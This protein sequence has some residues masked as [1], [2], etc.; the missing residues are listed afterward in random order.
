[1]PVSLFGKP[2]VTSVLNEWGG[3]SCVLKIVRPPGEAE[4]TPPIL[5]GGFAEHHRMSKSSTNS[6]Q[7]DVLVLTCTQSNPLLL[8]CLADSHVTLRHVWTGLQCV[9]AHL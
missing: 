7:L 9:R 1:M 4:D 5:R 3:E 6:F 2:W 8:P